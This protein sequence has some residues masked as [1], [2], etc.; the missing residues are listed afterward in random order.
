MSIDRYP[1]ELVI[2]SQDFLECGWKGI[3]SNTTR[4]GYSSMWQAF[5]SAARQASED[6]LLARGKVLWLLADACSMS[7]VPRSINEPF[8]PFMIMEDKRTVIPDDFLDLDMAFFASIVD[9]IDDPW[10]KARISDLVWF[11]HKPRNFKFALAAIDAYQSVPIDATTWWVGAHQGWERAISLALM[12]KSGAG[13][14]FREI[15]DTLTR[16]INCASYQ[17]GFLALELSNMLMSYG[18][19]RDKTIDIARKLK[20]L[21]VEFDNRGDLHRARDYFN[22]SAKWFKASGD[23]VQSTEMTVCEAECWVKEAIASISSESP[24]HLLAANS[25]ESAIQIYRTIPRTERASYQVDERI[26]SLR[27][28]LN[29]VGEKSLDEMGTI[30]TG[31]VDISKIIQN[32]R[33]AVT[34]K[35]AVEALKA[36]ANLHN[37]AKAKELRD[38]AL[39]KLRDFPLQAMFASTV[40]SRDGRVI[41]KCPGFNLGGE[42]SSEDE[43]TIRAGMIRDYSILVSIVVQG[44][45]L[46]ALEV[47]LLEHRLR[48]SDFVALASQSPIVPKGR[49]RLFGKALFAGYDRD[50]VTAIHLLVPQ[51]EHMVRYHLKQAGAQTSNYDSEGIENENG[52]STIIDLPETPKVFGEDLAFEL[53]ALFC[54]AFGPN[55]RNELAHGLLDDEDCQSIYAVYAW[56]FGLKLVFRAYWNAARQVSPNKDMEGNDDQ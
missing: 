47:L 56:W 12:L 42:L 17:D 46:P 10:L 27:R 11:K 16:T 43:I 53:R 26:A 48:E 14:R 36:F 2:N 8:Q 3:L 1:A 55:L 37:G 19:G 28:H 9:M 51:I 4:E 24:S 40:M 30:S 21:A 20:S 50:F 45:I 6:G 39:K 34:G 38:G 33:N 32:A 41:A 29:E 35:A 52:L 49:E 22:V 54:D 44:D 18:L 7:L 23:A 15:E 25:Y 5:S 31:G 13:N